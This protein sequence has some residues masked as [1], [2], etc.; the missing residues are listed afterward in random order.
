M[1]D[2][3]SL[4]GSAVGIIS[5]GLSLCKT[6]VRYAQDVQGQSD[7]MKYLATKASNIRILLKSLRELIEETEN[8]LPDVAVDLESK[9]LGLQL[10][11]D[12]LKGPIEKYERTQ[13]AARAIYHFKKEELFEVRDC[14]QSMEMDLNTALNV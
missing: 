4:T 1:T 6:I 9:A 12:R 11:L 8:D 7:D 13:A 10:Y 2:P 5:L 14:L 3:L